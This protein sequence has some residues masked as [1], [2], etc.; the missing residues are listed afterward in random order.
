[1][2]NT[3]FVTFFVRKKKATNKPIKIIKE[4]TKK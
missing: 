4:E 2:Y 3:I 1:M